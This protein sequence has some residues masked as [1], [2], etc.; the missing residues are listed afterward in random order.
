[1]AQ[2]ARQFEADPVSESLTEMLLAAEIEAEALR[3]ALA[4]E[5]VARA[6]AEG[7]L[8][9]ARQS[10]E[11]AEK[12]LEAERAARIVAESGRAVSDAL[13]EVASRAVP[14]APIVYKTDGGSAW[15]FEFVRDGAD[16][17]RRVVAT[18]REKK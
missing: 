2:P 15:D 11:Q 14:A 5:R 13:L 9:Q 16:Q 8:S 10:L 17:L 1:M 12:T 3:E 7:A 6:G 18:P 4:I